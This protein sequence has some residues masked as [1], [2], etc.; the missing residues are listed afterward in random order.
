MIRRVACIVLLGW[1]VAAVGAAQTAPLTID[2]PDA[3]ARAKKYGLQLDSATLAVRQAAED[4]RQARAAT[5]P[6]VTG[7][8]GFLLTQGNG[9]P[10]GS[11]VTANGVH[12]YT[13]QVQAHEELLAAFRKGELRRTLAAEMTAKARVE[14]AARGLTTVVIQDYYSVLAAQ[15]HLTNARK[16]VA[17]AERF[18]DISS[19]QE[20]GGEVAHADVIKAQLLLQQRQR[21]V[22][23]AQL[24]ILK[25]KIA[26]AVLM[27]PEMRDD[28]ELTDDLGTAPKELPVPGEVSA[29]AI[30]TSPDIKTAASAVNEATQGIAIAKYGYLP[31]LGIDFWYGFNSNQLTYYTTIDNQ[32]FRNPG[33]QAQATLN[34]PIWSWGSI[35]SRVKQASYKEEQAK[36]DLTLAQRNVKANV[37]AAYQELRAAQEQLKSLQ[38]SATLSQESLRLTV[39]RY[40]AGEASAL[41]VSDA[42]TTLTQARNAYDDG[43]VRYRVASA[44][45]QT[46]TGNL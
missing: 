43:L 38:E 31:S 16:S 40:Q 15:R 7:V 36:I 10:T 23:D 17:E 27:F 32:K 4:R 35:R 44:T 26:I 8:N 13:E 22:Q 18:Y 1:A 45:L 42:Q 6:Q 24:A 3:L 39:L 12:L 33:Y 11:Y 34:V 19:K 9:S 14:V 20:K 2:L 29:Q 28:F 5:L 37:M 30:S 25:A 21:D 46:L 41:E